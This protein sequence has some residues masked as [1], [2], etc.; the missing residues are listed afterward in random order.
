[1]IG[2]SLRHAPFVSRLRYAESP[3]QDAADVFEPRLHS[4]VGK[5]RRDVAHGDEREDLQ[6]AGRRESVQRRADL[7]DVA[8]HH[9]EE[10]A[11]VE[12]AVSA[13]QSRLSQGGGPRQER[14]PVLEGGSPPAG[15]APLEPL[16]GGS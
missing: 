3:D 7:Q 6:R 10:R 4:L 5:L 11:A 1:M 8:R 12:E 13:G 15:G 9:R 14:R 2:P 16:T